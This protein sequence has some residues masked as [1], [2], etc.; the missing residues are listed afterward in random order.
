MVGAYRLGDVLDRLL[1]G[2]PKDQ[3]QPAL[4]LVEDRTGDAHA[5]GLAQRLQPRGDVD[6]FAV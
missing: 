3:R 1:A 6:A 5:A 2:R 4:D